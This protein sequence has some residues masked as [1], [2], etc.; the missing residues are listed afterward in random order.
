MFA[1]PTARARS[2]AGGKPSSTSRSLDAAMSSTASACV[3][4]PWV[5]LAAPTPARCKT[6][7]AM[8]RRAGMLFMNSVTSAYE[9]QPLAHTGTERASCAF[10]LLNRTS[11]AASACW[12]WPMR[13]FVNAG[14][15]C[16]FGNSGLAAMDCSISRTTL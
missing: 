4:S 12:N 2:G 9:A 15:W 11:N 3:R 5:I 6:E 16:G 7:C 13:W 14:L 10:V 1:L 8:T